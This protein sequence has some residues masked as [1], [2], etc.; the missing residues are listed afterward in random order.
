MKIWAQSQLQQSFL[1]GDLEKSADYIFYFFLVRQQANFES[2]QFLY[3]VII[4]LFSAR[5][6][7]LMLRIGPYFPKLL[8]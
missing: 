2:I 7:L 3:R 8:E 1:V 4:S 6:L 5:F